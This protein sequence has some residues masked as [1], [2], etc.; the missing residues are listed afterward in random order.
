MVSGVKIISRRLAALSLLYSQQY[1]VSSF[2]SHESPCSKP[3]PPPDMAHQN[4][5]DLFKKLG[6]DFEI[7]P[8]VTSWLTSP[9]GL[10]ARTYDDLLYACSED[11]VESP[12][13]AAK[14]TNKLLAV[15]R[16]WQA[17]HSLKRA[18]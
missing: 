12:I 6:D 7:D 11:G 5:I 17:W 16:L 3:N 15:S 14:P 1:L 4:V 8:K 2:P 18:R 10:A 9:D 13:D